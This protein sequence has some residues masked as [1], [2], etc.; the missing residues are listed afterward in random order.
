MFEAVSESWQKNFGISRRTAV[1]FSSLLG[2]IIGIFIEAEPNVGAWMDFVSIIIVPFG[3]V[4]GAISIYYILGWSD[5]RQE[6]EKGHGPL[7]ELF[8]NVARFVYVPLTILV[9]VLGLVYG[10]IG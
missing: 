8:G 10:G 1:V 3:A 9:L 2:L 7:P 4:L 5:V 6:L